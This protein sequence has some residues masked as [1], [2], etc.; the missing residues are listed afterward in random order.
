MPQGTRQM[1]MKAADWRL[2]LIVAL[3]Q[4]MIAA[5]L[6]VMPPSALRAGTARFRRLA[7]LVGHGSQERIIWAIE[8][9]GRRLRGISTCLVRA[10][11]AELLLGSPARPLCLTIGVRRAANGILE[12]HAWVADEDRVLIGATSDE[13]VPVLQWSTLSV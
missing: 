6:R 10:F 1:A 8:A 11:V 9:A 2:L 12:C 13:F 4:V 3:A 7:Q 5:A